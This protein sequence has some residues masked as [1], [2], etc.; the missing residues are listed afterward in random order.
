[1]TKILDKRAQAVYQYFP[2]AKDPKSCKI[3]KRW[4]QTVECELVD[5]KVSPEGMLLAPTDKR[6]RTRSCT[7]SGNSSWEAVL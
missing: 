4:T 5:Y 1:M 3:L 2:P 6:D 7:R